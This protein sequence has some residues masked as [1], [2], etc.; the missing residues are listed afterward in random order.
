MCLITRKSI[1]IAAPRVTNFSLIP[2]A[3]E[4]WIREGERSARVCVCVC[5]R[6]C[7]C[8]RVCVCVR[9]RACVCVC[10][11][12]CVPHCCWSQVLSVQGLLSIMAT[13]INTKDAKRALKDEKL[14]E[15]VRTKQ[16]SKYHPLDHRP[17]PPCL[18]SLSYS[19]CSLF[20][21]IILP[22][23]L[24]CLFG[25]HTTPLPPPPPPPCPLTT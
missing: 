24:C 4:D 25:T 22:L 14:Q 6:L 9:T 17:S 11:C 19:F 15:D 1:A 7:V 13:A 2:L 21:F 5:V 18:F 8:A 23:F 10:V 16:M 12:V 20:F 3:C